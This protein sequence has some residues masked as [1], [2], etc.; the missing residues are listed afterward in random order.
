MDVKSINDRECLRC[1]DCRK[2]CHVGAISFKP[3][4]K[5]HKTRKREQH[6]KEM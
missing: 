4:M 3:E 6:E 2:S 5:I 1:G